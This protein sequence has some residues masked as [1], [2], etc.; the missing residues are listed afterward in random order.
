ME[1]VG[2]R[3]VQQSETGLAFRLVD[4]RRLHAPILGAHQAVNLALAIRAAESFLGRSLSEP[5]LKSLAELRLPARIERFGDVILDCAHTPDSAR[6]LRQ[7]LSL[8]WP[9]RTWVLVV[10]ISRDKDAPKILSELAPHTRV[11]L[12]SQAEPNRS[13]PAEELARVARACGIPLVE[14]HPE[15][16]LAFERAQALRRPG[17]MGVGTGSVYFAGAVRSL[18][19]CGLGV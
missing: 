14:V 5:E 10:S 1:E 13:L 18:L 8:V 11:C 12:A 7:T 4:G 16:K 15:P 6:A 3:D 17:E 2:T 19:Q 9:Q